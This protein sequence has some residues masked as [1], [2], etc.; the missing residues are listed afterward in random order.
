MSRQSSLT[1]CDWLFFDVGNTLVDD[2]ACLEARIIETAAASRGSPWQIARSELTERVV[3]AASSSGT[4]YQTVMDEIGVA[5]RAPRSASVR[6]ERVAGV[7]ASR[8]LSAWL[9]F[10]AGLPIG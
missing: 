7:G 8:C 2:A 5:Y 10:I 9:A 6:N 4:P 1:R 3:R